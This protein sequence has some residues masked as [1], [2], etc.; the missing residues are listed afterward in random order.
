MWRWADN[1]PLKYEEIQLNAVIPN[2][3]LPKI[4]VNEAIE[5]DHQS[6]VITFP[7]KIVILTYHSRVETV[8]QDGDLLKKQICTYDMETLL[9]G[10]SSIKFVDFHKISSRF[11]RRKF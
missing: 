3:F 8:N 1:I 6:A 10:K 9:P 11:F 2:G 4:S 7:Q 5:A